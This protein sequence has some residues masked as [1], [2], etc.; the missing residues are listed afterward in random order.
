MTEHASVY[1]GGG[2]GLSIL[3]LTFVAAAAVIVAA[4]RLAHKTKSELADEVKDSIADAV[5]A[6]RRR[7]ASKE[8]VLSEKERRFVLSAAKETIL[9]EMTADK[10]DAVKDRFSD[11]YGWIRRQIEARYWECAPEDERSEDFLIFEED[12]AEA[13]AGSEEDEIVEE[14]T[15]GTPQDAADDEGSAESTEEAGAEEGTVS[16]SEDSEEKPNP[17]I[18]AEKTEPEKPSGEEVE[19]DGKS[20]EE[21]PEERSGGKTDESDSAEDSHDDPKETERREMKYG[22]QEKEAASS[23]APATEAVVIYSNSEGDETSATIS[24]GRLSVS[25]M[26]RKD[27]FPQKSAMIMDENQTACLFSVFGCAKK[28]DKNKLKALKSRFSAY[29][30]GAYAEI[31]RTCEENGVGF[32]EIA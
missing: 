5:S 28:S 22:P 14:E 16:E 2:L 25:W 32:D 23:E 4:K 24:G 31:K 26:T 21:T 29:K 18:E 11:A 7:F 6:T 27:G 1:V 10:L 20:D 15:V 17:A 13:D 3:F 30:H 9:S 19:A 8:E 12:E